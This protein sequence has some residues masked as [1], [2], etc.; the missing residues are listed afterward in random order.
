MSGG[1]GYERPLP[2]TRRRALEAATAA[3]MTSSGCASSRHNVPSGTRL[4]DA[5]PAQPSV[6]PVRKALYDEKCQGH[7]CCRHD[8]RV[9]STPRTRPHPRRP[10]LR[11]RIWLDPPSPRASTNGCGLWG[12]PTWPLVCHPSPEQATRGPFH[13]TCVHAWSGKDGAHIRG[14][15]SSRGHFSNGGA[16]AV[17]KAVAKTAGHAVTT[18]RPGCGP[19]RPSWP[20]LLSALRMEVPDCCGISK[21]QFYADAGGS[22]SGR[23]IF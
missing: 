23:C 14:Q 17:T 18:V 7:G 13:R 2:F 11:P 12:L 5:C 22:R 19:H 10:D 9:R 21:G 3:S 20:V 1:S 6:R 16:A 8:Q 15:W 4:V